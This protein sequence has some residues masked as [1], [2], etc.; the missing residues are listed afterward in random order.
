MNQQAIIVCGP[1][2]SG[3]L[4]VARDVARRI[5]GIRRQCAWSEFVAPIPPRALRQPAAVIIVDG[6]PDSDL[7]RERAEQ[8]MAS[9][10]P[11]L[12]FVARSADAFARCT[13]FSVVEV[14]R[15]PT[16]GRKAHVKHAP[17]CRLGNRTGLA[18]AFELVLDFITW[19]NGLHAELT[20]EQIRD[21]WEV[22][23]AT[24]YRWLRAWQDARAKGA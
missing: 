9:L 7:A 16:P 19:A 3:A 11:Q 13:E 15:K 8:K 14:E 24:S 17:N 12:I 2:G 22:S 1:F 21:H 6:L 20:A 10:E 5:G 4:T 23:R 18:S